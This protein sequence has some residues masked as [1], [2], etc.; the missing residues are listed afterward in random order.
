MK[1]QKRVKNTMVMVGMVLL[2]IIAITITTAN[3]TAV[4]TEDNSETATTWASS[5]LK[6]NLAQEMTL[7][8][9]KKDEEEN[10]VASMMVQQGE[11]AYAIKIVINDVN[12]RTMKVKKYK[13]NDIQR[14]QF[15]ETGNPAY[16]TI[17]KMV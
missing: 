11:R 13:K 7:A 15:K 16:M 6:T 2:M 10:N 17:K 4:L 9:Q 14:L 8:H 12:E 1:R 3:S 5:N